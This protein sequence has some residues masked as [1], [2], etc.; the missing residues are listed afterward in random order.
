VNSVA[1]RCLLWVGLAMSSASALAADDV[2]TG[3]ALY[4]AKCGGCHSV[5]T[6]RI[7]PL[8]RGVVGRKIASIADFAYSSAI[9]KLTGNWTP[10]KLDKWLQDPQKVAPG[11][12]MYFQDDDAAERRAIIAFLKSVSPPGGK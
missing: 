12:A 3:K 4:D 11:T 5:D 2:A 9:R 10:E 6:N 1:Q 8:H 7:G